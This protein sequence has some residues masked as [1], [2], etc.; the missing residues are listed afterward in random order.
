MGTPS[1]GLPYYLLPPS[2]EYSL[3]KLCD[4]PIFARHSLNWS[5]SNSSTQGPIL[6][7]VL[8]HKEGS[9]RLNNEWT[10]IPRSSVCQ[11]LQRTR[12]WSQSGQLQHGGKYLPCGMSQLPTLILQPHSF[13]TW[14]SW[15]RI[16]APHLENC[17]CSSH[18]SG[19]QC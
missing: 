5:L 6:V 1:W 10:E 11:V 19:C 9:L 7:T 8:T 12:S 14:G 13:M 3:L 2:L 18:L 15:P 16:S 17:C 4:N